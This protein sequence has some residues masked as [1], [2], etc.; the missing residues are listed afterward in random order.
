MRAYV[1]ESFKSRED[2]SR[3]ATVT[4]GMYAWLEDVAHE[5]TNAGSGILVTPSLALTAAHVPNDM[6]SLD[7]RVSVRLRRPE[8]RL[9]LAYSTRLYQVPRFGKEVAWAVTE[10]WCSTETDLALMAIVP[11][12]PLAATLSTEV[13]PRAVFEWRLEPP[14]VGAVVDLFGFPKAALSNEATRHQ[15]QVQWVQQTGVVTDIFEPFRTH[16]HL[17]FPCFRVDRP[18]DNGF[19][20]GPVFYDGALV[21]I[22]SV[23]LD[24]G[25]GDSSLRDTYVA[26]LWPLAI[27]KIYQNG[28]LRE[29]AELFDDQTI[30]VRD[31]PQM[32]GR[33]ERRT[34]DICLAKDDAHR[35]HPTRL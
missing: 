9:E 25:S 34:C 4:F 23:S 26:A 7:P 14:P 10:T 22:T 1:S 27:T 29:V 24:V 15:G 2:L 13:L 3:A 16:G 5:I 33:I 17:E 32:K 6:M 35:G 19:S 8:E 20:G 18:V 11:D 21:G 30:R 12:S 28:A 31:W